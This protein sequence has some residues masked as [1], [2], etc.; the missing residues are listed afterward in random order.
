MSKFFPLKNKP[1]YF[2][3]SRYYLKQHFGNP[4]SP[5]PQMDFSMQ[6]RFINIYLPLNFIY[7]VKLKEKHDLNTNEVH[8]TERGKIK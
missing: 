8:F 7:K 3:S 4:P 2:D 1:N 5:T 6:F